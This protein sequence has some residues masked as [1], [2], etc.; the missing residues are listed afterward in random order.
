[1]SIECVMLS[2]PGSLEVILD[3]RLAQDDWRGLGE[4]L[5]DNVPVSSEFVLL[6]ETLSRRPTDYVS[7]SA[8]IR[9]SV[10]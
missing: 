9:K 4:G 3:R 7:I 5:I 1:M 10:S 8:S 2:S 6:F